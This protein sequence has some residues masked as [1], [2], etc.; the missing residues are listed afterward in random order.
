MNNKNKRLLIGAITGA[1]IGGGLGYLSNKSKK[2]KDKLESAALGALYGGAAGTFIG[3]KYHKSKVKSFG[4][5]RENL[6]ELKKHNI[7]FNRTS[8]E[9]AKDKFGILRYSAGD[10]YMANDSGVAFLGKTKRP[11]ALLDQSTTSAIID[12]LYDKIYSGSSGFPLMTASI[13]KKRNLGVFP[14]KIYS[15]TTMAV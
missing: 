10:P 2:K 9:N 12:K 1:G 14:K 13:Y 11:R 6:Q 5:A 7:D 8:N 15:R 3:H 4:D